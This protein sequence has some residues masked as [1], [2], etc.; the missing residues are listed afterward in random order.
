MLSQEKIDKMNKKNS[1]EMKRKKKSNER[2]QI[3]WVLFV[4]RYLDS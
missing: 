1:E 4:V 3:P 2:E